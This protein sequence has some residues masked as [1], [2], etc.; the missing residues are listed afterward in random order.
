LC[1]PYCCSSSMH[2]VEESLEMSR[3]LCTDAAEAATAAPF[4]GWIERCS[5]AAEGSEYAMGAMVK[6]GGGGRR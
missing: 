1:A 4:V 5:R 3:A 6:D 2:S